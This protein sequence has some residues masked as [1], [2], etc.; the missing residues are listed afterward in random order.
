MCVCVCVSIYSYL[1]EV[2]NFRYTTYIS[3]EICENQTNSKLA[4][5]C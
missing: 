3:G 2:S 5:S 4:V 1:C